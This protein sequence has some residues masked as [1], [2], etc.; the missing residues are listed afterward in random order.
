MQ[1]N[2]EVSPPA[3]KMN[4]RLT[5]TYVTFGFDFSVFFL[6]ICYISWDMTYCLVTFCP[7]TDIH[8][9]YI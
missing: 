7:M 9:E 2:V 1:F 6:V 8:T 4:L 3:N 5:L